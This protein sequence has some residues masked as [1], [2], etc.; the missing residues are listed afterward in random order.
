MNKT[1]ILLIV[2]GFILIG[3][4]WMP[5]FE[6]EKKQLEQPMFGLSSN[7]E[8]SEMSNTSNTS[9]TPET[10]NTSETSNTS[11][12]DI[13]WVIATIQSLLGMVLLFKKIFSKGK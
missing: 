1:F 2:A 11:K 5:N 12:K 8:T 3:L 10:Q 13:T 4:M 9:N 7:S 6:E